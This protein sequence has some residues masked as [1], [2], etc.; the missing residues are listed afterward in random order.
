MQLHCHNAH[1]LPCHI[2][3][4]CYYLQSSQYIIDV[5]IEFHGALSLPYM[6]KRFGLVICFNNSFKLVDTVNDGLNGE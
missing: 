2:S 4:M 3:I 5:S 1:F 6:D